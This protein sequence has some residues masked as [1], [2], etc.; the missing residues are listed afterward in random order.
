MVKPLLSGRVS[1]SQ[2]EQ[3]APFLP[4]HNPPKSHC[5]YSTAAT[6]GG[7]GAE[8]DLLYLYAGRHRVASDIFRL[9]PWTPLGNL[10]HHYCLCILLLPSS[11]QKA[12]KFQKA[13]G[14][15]QQAS[16]SRLGSLK[17][18]KSLIDHHA[19]PTHQETSKTHP[20]G[21]SSAATFFGPCL[22]PV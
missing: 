22:W 18:L 4:K 20:H 3:Y 15:R 14:K 13:N 8:Q 9:Q 5:L 16:L 2:G 6:A 7:N 11:L 17:S 12:S 21:L 10:V 1:R 19:R